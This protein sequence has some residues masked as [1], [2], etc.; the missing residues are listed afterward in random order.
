MYYLHINK[1][2]IYQIEYLSSPAKGDVCLETPSN[3][4]ASGI[5]PHNIATS[6]Y[7]APPTV[8]NIL[9]KFG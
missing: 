8:S 4:V 9:H 2:V 7:K 5:Q 1:K 3:N 6:T